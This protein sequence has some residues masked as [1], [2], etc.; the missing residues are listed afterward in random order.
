MVPVTRAQLLVALKRYAE[1][2]S[3]FDS[4]LDKASEEGMSHREPRFLADRA[5][6]QAQR[7][8]HTDAARDLRYA[9]AA[10][11]A[12]VDDDDRAATLAR[13]SATL[14]VLGRDAEASR[15][16]GLADQALAAHQAVQ[17]QWHEA[18][19]R[20]VAGAA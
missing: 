6:C 4:C 5:W 10:L 9:E 11:V 8:Y 16:R 15:L 20:A 2:A 19:N 7:G 17:R 18:L 14:A 12:L 1:A 13:M 3:L